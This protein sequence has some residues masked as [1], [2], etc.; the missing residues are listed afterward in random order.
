MRMSNRWRPIKTA[1]KDGTP[2]LIWDATK[3]AGNYRP[4]DD[5][6]YAIGYWRTDQP[7]GEWMWGNRN[8]SYVSPTHWQPLPNPPKGYR[9]RKFAR[10]KESK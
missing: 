3:E 1:P 5:Q 8:S 10:T 2:I 7:D 9:S 4:Y 6:R